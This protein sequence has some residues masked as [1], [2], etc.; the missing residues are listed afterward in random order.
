MSASF[1]VC[2]EHCT[3][4][5]YQRFSVP[6][7][8]LLAPS[9]ILLRAGSAMLL[10][11]NALQLASFSQISRFIN[12]FKCLWRLLY[13]VYMATQSQSVPNHRIH[14]KKSC[15]LLF[16]LKVYETYLRQSIW[17]SQ[18]EKWQTLSPSI[19]LSFIP[20]WSRSLEIILS[21]ES[22]TFIYNRAVRFLKTVFANVS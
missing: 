6:L 3:K 4:I 20:Y 5:K 2:F 13:S 17:I 10:I 15:F 21:S 14:L 22:H 12:V 19:S 1:L 18:P 16:P 11:E 8:R 7:F 9:C